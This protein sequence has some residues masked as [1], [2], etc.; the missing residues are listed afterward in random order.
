MNITEIS[1][2][3]TSI[4]S[5]KDNASISEN[6]LFETNTTV[7]KIDTSRE[8]IE[9]S[10]ISDSNQTGQDLNNKTDGIENSDNLA[11]D[12]K[13]SDYFHD[14]SVQI[15]DNKSEL[16]IPSNSYDILD[17]ITYDFDISNDTYTVIISQSNDIFNSTNNVNQTNINIIETD[18]NISFT[19][20]ES[21]I[22]FTNT[23]S[24]ESETIINST[25]NETF[26]IDNITKYEN[27]SI[28]EFD[29]SNNTNKVITETI[30]EIQSLNSEN[31]KSDFNSETIGI[32]ESSIDI[33][34][35]IDYITNNTEIYEEEPSTT[36]YPETENITE[37]HEDITNE[38][39][40]SLNDTII[41][42]NSNERVDEIS[43]ASNQIINTDE[44]ITYD[45]DT[46]DESTYQNNISYISENDT[47]TIE[48]EIEPSI[49][50]P[51]TYTDESNYIEITEQLNETDET[52]YTKNSVNISK[53]SENINNES[54]NS[55]SDSFIQNI[56]TI[57]DIN[58][59]ITKNNIS[60]I[61]ISTYSNFPEY[62]NNTNYTD[63]INN[64]TINYQDN[65]SIPIFIDDTININKTELI[66]NKTDFDINENNETSDIINQTDYGYDKDNKSD[67]IINTE[68]AEQSDTI[69]ESDSFYGNA[70]SITNRT[71]EIYMSSDIIYDSIN[72]TEKTDNITY[73]RTEINSI[74]VTYNID[75]MNDSHNINNSNFIENT[76]GIEMPES[77]IINITEYNIDHLTENISDKFISDN[78]INESNITDIITNNISDSQQIINDSTDIIKIN[79][80]NIL[81]NNEYN[82]S[83][84]DTI[85]E[86]NILNETNE[87]QFTTITSHIK[88]PDTKKNYF[89]N[90]SIDII[91]KNKTNIL[92][93][94]ELNSSNRNIIIIHMILLL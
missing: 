64:E 73:E 36:I 88:S 61:D 70:T 94:D 10:I 51:I 17:N 5:E 77:Y 82:S 76:T 7:L 65:T 2:I 74:N 92:T 25:E 19:E 80:T 27:N 9:P 6:P 47:N 59:N 52:E 13:E 1:D 86:T 46:I 58:I 15:N 24:I 68:K 84:S 40:Y 12:T 39:N 8:I 14:D 16:I 89:I 45:N 81:T 49:I 55:A 48:I 29:F 41:S 30:T 11:Q 22:E 20:T 66:I 62:L 38:S 75:N 4:N 53:E 79:E 57:T 34:N 85:K 54:L 72:Y 21:E 71:S 33:S 50:I 91:K 60:E 23:N 56:D 43:E 26:K 93:T 83:I 32:S 63:Y 37:Y 3:Y 87:A 42:N 69:N 90:N 28:N 44:N 31:E 78:S 18:K 35:Y 67:T